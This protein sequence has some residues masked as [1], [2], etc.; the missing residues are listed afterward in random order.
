MGLTR[1]ILGHFKTFFSYILIKLKSVKVV[2]LFLY[3]SGT[4]LGQSGNASVR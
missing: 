3:L 2:F 4:S 1:P